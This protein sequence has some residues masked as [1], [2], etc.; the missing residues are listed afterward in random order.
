MKKIIK[1]LLVSSMQDKF[2]LRTISFSFRDAS[3]AYLFC[4]DSI[5]NIKI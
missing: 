1:N 3:E 2:V 5:I 4:F